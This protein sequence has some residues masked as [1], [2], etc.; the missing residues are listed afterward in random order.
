MHMSDQMKHDLPNSFGSQD[1][2]Q[3]KV[4]KSHSIIVDLDY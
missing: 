1:R 4:I 3:H 2:I